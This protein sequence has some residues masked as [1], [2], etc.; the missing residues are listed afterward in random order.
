MVKGKKACY[1]QASFAKAL[2]RELVAGSM[3]ADALWGRIAAQLKPF[4]ANP[5]QP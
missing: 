2:Q 5:E 3:K 1:I 4:L